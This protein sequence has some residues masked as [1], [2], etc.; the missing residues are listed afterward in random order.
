MNHDSQHEEDETVC[1][2]VALLFIAVLVALFV[3][4]MIN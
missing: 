4:A 3:I 2:Q 1:M